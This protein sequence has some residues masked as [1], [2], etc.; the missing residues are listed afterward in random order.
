MRV[1]VHLGYQ[2][3]NG[4]PDAE[5]FMQEELVDY[6]LNRASMVGDYEILALSLDALC[7]GPPV[8]AAGYA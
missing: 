8:C 1:A 3:L 6:H 7:D 2:N 4:I 5:K